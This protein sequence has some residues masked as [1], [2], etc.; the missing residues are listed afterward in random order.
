VSP[1]ERIKH[2]LVIG[3][4]VVGAIGCGEKP[5]ADDAL[6]A[7]QVAQTATF[8]TLKT[9]GA[10]RAESLTLYKQWVDG[11]TLE[12]RD[13]AVVLTWAAPDRFQWRRLRDGKLRQEILLADGEGWKRTGSRAYQLLGSTEVHQSALAEH[14]RLWETAL[15]PFE[16]RIELRPMG[17]GLVEGRTAWHY[18]VALIPAASTAR[19]TRTTLTSLEGSVWID[20]ATAVRLVAEVSGSWTTLGR[21]PLH[22]AIEFSLVRSGFGEAQDVRPP[23]TMRKRLDD[24]PEEGR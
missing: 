5:T 17:D 23:F 1:R 9:L 2:A 19:E 24:E 14:W 6:L 18:A 15:E 3:C 12:E 13:L 7:A 8:E 22:H 21:L 10:H 16:G 20:K 11:G 4:A